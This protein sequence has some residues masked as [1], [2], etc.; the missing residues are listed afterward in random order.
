MK[1]IKIS[2][3]YARSLVELSKEK[4]Q[5]DAVLV[6]MELVRDTIKSS[7]E[8]SVLLNSPVVKSDTKVAVLNRI[9]GG[10]IGAIAHGFMKLLTE[11]GRE[12]YLE[13]VAESFVEQVRF[14]KDIVTARVTTAVPLDEATR[15]D[16]LSVARK[17]SHGDIDIV[18]TVDA[19]V[20]GGFVLQVGD[21]MIDTSIATSLKN[22]KRNF[23]DNPYIPDL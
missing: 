1:G 7:R 12:G 23:D 2:S 22:M 9:F 19:T 3:R 16:I 14:Y 18:E 10:N 21:K 17:I 8:L 20:I 11:K 4:G 5:V 13:E 15:Q 6:D